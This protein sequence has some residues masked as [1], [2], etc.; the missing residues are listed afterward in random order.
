M[1]EKPDE[2]SGSTETPVI[3]TEAPLT[4]KVGDSIPLQTGVIVDHNG[5]Q[6]P[7]GTVVRFLIDT[8][9]TSGSIEQI[10]TQTINGI[11][12]TSYRIQNI[13]VFTLRVTADP[14]Q[15]SQILN[16]EITDAGGQI[17]SFEPTLA[18][19]GVASSTAVIDPQ[20][21]LEIQELSNHE[22]GLLS[23]GDW[24]VST[25]IIFSIAVILYWWG[26]QKQKYSWSPRIPFGSILG[27][28]VVYFYFVL[29]MPGAANGIK[30]TGSGLILAGVVLGCL[31][32]GGIGY[33]WYAL[34]RSKKV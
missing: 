20:E 23:A 33:L 15:I 29:G 27:G 5:N 18:P 2:E 11:A 6:V 1:V 7:D 8:K 24:L 19:T 34:E 16:L 22:Q 28:Y 9:S 3:S 21:T 13:G 32:G 30:N 4:Y 12:R 31:V 25:I 26:W 17:T 10:E 14:A